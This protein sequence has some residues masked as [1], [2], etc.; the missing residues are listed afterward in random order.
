MSTLITT[1]TKIFSIKV[2]S[3]S[4]A[5]TVK[6]VLLFM[7]GWK[8]KCYSLERFQWNHY[9]RF[10]SGSGKSCDRRMKKLICAWNHQQNDQIKT[11]KMKIISDKGRN[12]PSAGD[13][14]VMVYSRTEVWPPWSFC[15]INA[16]LCDAGRRW[17]DGGS[18]RQLSPL[19]TLSL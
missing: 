11:K 6:E 13:C 7:S 8:V 10:C 1:F 17:G 2:P 5:V 12:F 18:S 14:K 15:H 3:R 16:R 9:W 4:P 19:P